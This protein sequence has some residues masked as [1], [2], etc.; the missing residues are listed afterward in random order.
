MN[1]E[2]RPKVHEDFL[3]TK[4][5]ILAQF[6]PKGWIRRDKLPLINLHK[7]SKNAKKIFYFKEWMNRLHYDGARIDKTLPWSKSFSQ[8]RND[9]LKRI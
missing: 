6:V 2:S 7:S 9:N 4:M 5:G 3:T 8:K 1:A